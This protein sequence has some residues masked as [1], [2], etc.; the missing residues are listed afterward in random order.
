M[1][2]LVTILCCL[3]IC[4]PLV[5][6]QAPDTLWTRFYGTGNNETASSILSI[7]DNGF[8]VAGTRWQNSY[9]NFLVMKAD[10]NG[11][12]LWSRSVGV[13]NQSEICRAMCM[14][15]DGGVVVAGGGGDGTHEFCWLKLNSS[16]DSIWSYHSG[17]YTNDSCRAVLYHPNNLLFLAGSGGNSG[18]GLQFVL[19]TTAWDG[20]PF[21]RR[22]FGGSGD[23]ICVALSP[24]YDG[25]LL[26][27]GHT[28][29]LGNGG[30]DYWVVKT[31][32]ANGTF[33]RSQAYGGSGDDKCTS[34]CRSV[35]GG[36]AIAGYTTSFGAQGL[37]FLV[38]KID[39]GMVSQWSRRYGG[40]NDD[41]CTGIQTT[42][43]GGYI[44]CGFTSVQ[45]GSSDY[46]LLR[47]N[48]DGDSLWSRNLNSG[49]D[50]RATS[51]CVSPNGSY[52]IAGYSQ[53]AQSNN[54]WWITRVA[55]EWNRL[56]LTSPAPSANVQLYTTC[57]ITWNTTG[58]D[59]QVY[60]ALNRH[61]P[62]GEWESIA[63]GT[64]NDGVFEWFVTDPLS[65]SCRIRVCAFADTV[66]GISEGSF[67]I[68]SSQGYLAF[69]Q[70]N[71]PNNPISFWNA[72]EYECPGI[73][74]QAF[75]VKNFGD[76]SIS[77]YPP[78]EPNGGQFNISSSCDS[79]FVLASNS[80][81]SCSIQV[82]FVPSAEGFHFDT[83]RLQTNAVNGIG[84]YVSIPLSGSQT[85]TPASPQVVITTQGQDARLSWEPVTLSGGD[86]PINVTEYIVFFAEESEG[87]FW[88]H[89]FTIDTSYVHGRV[90][91]HADGMF[92]HVVASTAPLSLLLDLP[93]SGQNPPISEDQVL[94]MLRERRIAYEH[95]VD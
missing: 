31:R 55:P 25:E 56:V 27:A 3:A 93:P 50:D 22:E 62:L 48:S 10:S 39:T 26:L 57:N 53:V 11:E 67:S 23:E 24:T 16:G 38:T 46:W 42:S 71:A 73:V 78:S 35:D 91:T 83:L 72:G 36:H 37:D 86:C 32:S 64:P 13:G 58:V 74:S 1:K 49:F 63:S 54:D 88:Y 21:Y 84:G 9:S 89:G 94:E 76:E 4:A 6:A 65:D 85:R 69:I 75:W 45:G 33:L 47:L 28:N 15:P 82:S 66:C 61:Y 95:V 44:L 17:L 34:I 80:V 19:L 18:T 77:I 41:V 90:I 92:Y 70:S 43:D 52:I 5:N 81:S 7:S 40:V 60:I 20:S 29:S 8:V 68:V 79:L 51:L 14:T 30:F 87:P 12:V 59:T 2:T